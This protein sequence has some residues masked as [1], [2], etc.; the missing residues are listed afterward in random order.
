MTQLLRQI[1]SS[2]LLPLLNVLLIL[3]GER[4]T[5]ALLAVENGTK[6]KFFIF[7]TSSSY[8]PVRE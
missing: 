1:A 8:L 7:S 2:F 6:I 3:A 5:A 4:E